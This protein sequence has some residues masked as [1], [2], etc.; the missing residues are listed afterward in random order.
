[1]SHDVPGILL[2]EG[3]RQQKKILSLLNPD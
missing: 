2:V 1:L 3:L